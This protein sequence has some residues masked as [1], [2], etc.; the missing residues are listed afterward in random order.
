MLTEPRDLAADAVLSGVRA[1]WDPAVTWAEHVP[2]GAGAF[3]WRVGTPAGA[4][5]FAT[6]DPV[7]DLDDARRRANAY[8]AA[9]QL[10]SVLDFVAGPV[11]GLHGETATRLGASYLLT[12][13]PHLDAT[14]VTDPVT[15]DFPDDGARADVCSMLARLHTARRPAGIPLWQPRIGWR[16]TARRA[17]LEAVRTAPIWGSGPLGPPAWRVVTGAAP[18]LDRA[19][20]RFDLLAGAATGTAS[21]WVPTHGEPHAANVMATAGGPRL[22]DW[23]TLAVAPPERDLRHVLLEAEG[24]DPE[25]AYL[26]SGGAPRAMAADLIE[27]FELEWHLSEVAETAA[28][29]AAPHDGTADDERALEALDV[30]LAALSR[31]WG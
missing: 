30:D 1:G 17:Q 16:S 9:A 15:G 28:Q 4:R 26:A 31:R 25:L 21:A 3:H 22:G 11:P 29:L 14:P 8:T 27:L 2:V 18:L 23:A 6:A 5:W 19:L 13:A 12:V 24:S 10:S 20:R 7:V